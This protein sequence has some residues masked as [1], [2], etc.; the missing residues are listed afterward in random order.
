M[1]KL[2]IGLRVFAAVLLFVTLPVEQ[3]GNGTDVVV[4]AR[5]SKP[6]RISEPHLAIDSANS[7]H[8]LVSAFIA[9][10]TQ[11]AAAEQSCA[12]FVS[13][14][15]GKTWTRHDFTIRGC[16]DPQVAILPDGHAVF[17]AVGRGVDAG[18]QARSLIHV[19]RSMDGGVKWES[20][21]TMVVGEDHPSLAVDFSGSPRRGWLYMTVNHFTTGGD[22]RRRV[23]MSIVRSRD[24]GQTF[25]DPVIL[26]PNNLQTVSET[27]VVL[28]DGTLVASFVDEVL[29]RPFFDRRRA[30]VTRSTDGGSTFSPPS[31]ITDACGPPPT[32]QL[33]SLA[34]DGSAGPS[35]DHLYFA[36]R[37]SAGGPIVVTSSSDRGENWTRP[38]VAV[39]DTRID[40]DIWR[41]PVLA[42]N[43]SGTVGV[44]LVERHHSGETCHT[45][46]FVGSS[47]GAT[48]LGSAL[49]I[50]TASCGTS[51]E[52]EVAWRRFPTY[53]DYFG[54]AAQGDGRFR[55]VWPEMRNGTSTLLT[56]SVGY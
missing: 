44:M 45:V 34:V 4:I 38:A 22:G 23:K 51:A 5:E 8:Y 29:G 43:S 15:A 25:D 1:I 47:D 13:T 18:S 35:R 6:R 49:R 10:T 19:Y 39:G 16:G 36:C 9:E 55:L 32:F 48:I 30:W 53:G 20:T 56:A 11:D 24:G 41:V 40:S 54:F 12:T 14:D 21:P 2:M 33:S 28:S 46:N 27:P 17:A 52:D 50:S 37:Q 31:F 26:S 42:V 3:P 7:R